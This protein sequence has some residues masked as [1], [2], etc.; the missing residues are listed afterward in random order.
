MPS[1][2]CTVLY[3]ARA[4]ELAGLGD[5]EIEVVVADESALATT[6]DVLR[7]VIALHPGI[8]ELFSA[9]QGQGER[10]GQ[11]FVLALNQEYVEEPTEVQDGDEVAIIPP[12]SGG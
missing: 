7:R 8:S 4:K 6:D 10:S 1:V 11:G 9:E 5:E 12:I 2:H 3:F